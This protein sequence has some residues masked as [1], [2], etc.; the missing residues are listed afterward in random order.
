MTAPPPGES[1]QPG[2]PDGPGEP[3]LPRD[4]GEQRLASLLA[5]LADDPDAP[6]STVTA[7]SV[8]AAVRAQSGTA[9]AGVVVVDGRKRFR[10]RRGVVVGLLAAACVAAVAAVVIPLSLRS[11][12][13][14]TSAESASATD[15][16]SAQS[17]NASSEVFAAQ[18]ATAPQQS[19][20][21]LSAPAAGS[22]AAVA[23]GVA[24]GQSDAGL[25]GEPPAPTEPEVSTSVAGCAWSPLSTASASALTAS[26]AQSFPAGRFGAP[27]PLIAPCPAEP[28]AGARLPDATGGSLVVTVITAQPGACASGS[29]TT[30]VTESGVRCVSQGSGRYL[31]TDTGGEQTAYAY[32][33]GLEVAVGKDLLGTGLPA[34]A[35]V[36]ADQLLA[37]AQAVLGAQG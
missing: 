27:G 26:L 2:G 7:E 35:P 8:L 4:P 21:D 34:G 23:P 29:S 15:Q 28:I 3:E 20:A 30:D 17:R 11:S 6:A 18:S 9:A 19:A 5:E 12:E 13:T 37:A 32:G 31:S 14:T 10:G 36:G 1:T 25:P 16:G 33:G 22:M 24:S